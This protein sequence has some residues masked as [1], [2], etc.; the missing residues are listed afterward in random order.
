MF[1]RHRLRR[2]SLIRF[3]H[4]WK[5][6]Q[7]RGGRLSESPNGLLCSHSNLN[8]KAR[9][10]L[11]PGCHVRPRRAADPGNLVF[12]CFFLTLATFVYGLRVDPVTVIRHYDFLRTRLSDRPLLNP[13]Y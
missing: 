3:I 5:G 8:N 11:D 9:L 4:C 6:N 12:D 1:I 10:L 2:K 7:N 13:L